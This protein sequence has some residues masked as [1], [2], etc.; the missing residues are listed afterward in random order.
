MFISPS[1]ALMF[2]TQLPE[3]LYHVFQK[4]EPPHTEP[5]PPIVKLASPSINV[6][7][8]PA[9]MKLMLLVP[10]TVKLVFP[11]PL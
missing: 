9:P 5:V 7:L 2:I 6:L 4:P 8:I 10:G 11:T 3:V 1:P